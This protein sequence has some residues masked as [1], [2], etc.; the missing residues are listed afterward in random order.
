MRRPILLLLPWLLLSTQA[1]GEEPPASCPGQPTRPGA[2]LSAYL[3]CPKENGKD[4]RNWPSRDGGEV[5]LTSVG[6]LDLTVS[7]AEVAEDA[8]GGRH[9]SITLDDEGKCWF[10]KTTAEHIGE[11]LALVY[12]GKVIIAPVIRSAIHT[13]EIYLI[14]GF[15]KKPTEYERI[16]RV[17]D[18]NCRG[19]E[20]GWERLFRFLKDFMGKVWS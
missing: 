19:L 7:T 20:T 2:L 1:F 4:C 11:K 9:I 13:G 12:D 15:D 10:H 14:L 6:H 8:V 18:P 3:S 5:P 16:C 17:L